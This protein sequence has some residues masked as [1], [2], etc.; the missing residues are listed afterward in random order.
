MANY[1]ETDKMQGLFFYDKSCRTD[2]VMD[3]WMMEAKKF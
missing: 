3:G 1:K 2:P